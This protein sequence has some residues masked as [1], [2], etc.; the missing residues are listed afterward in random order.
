MKLRILQIIFL[1]AIICVS[2]KD[3]SKSLG[4]YPILKASL[5]EKQVSIHDIFKEAVIIPLETTQESPFRYPE[6]ICVYNDTVYVFDSSLNSLYIFGIDGKYINKIHRVGQGPEEYIL[7]YDFLVNQYDN[8]IELLNPMGTIHKYRMDGTFVRRDDLPKPPMNYRYF[9]LLD[10]EYYAVWSMVQN[11]ENSLNIL[12]SENYQN[13]GGYFPHSGM[14]GAFGR[15][16]FYL[17]NDSLYYYECM[18]NKVYHLTQDG[19]QTVYEWDFGMGIIDPK[20]LSAPLEKVNEA[21]QELGED[22]KEGK[23]PFCFAQQFQTDK[24]YYASLRFG[25]YT[26]KSLFYDKSTGESL[27][28]E[29][30]KEGIK[31]IPGIMTNEYMIGLLSYEDKETLRSVVSPA[32]AKLLDKMKEEDNMWLVK[33]TFK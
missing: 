29:K 5:V 26:Q 6:K 24:Y 18:A 8:T 22:F 17:Y 20:R 25:F 19:Y 27:F 23:I 31:L 7:V 10:K 12:T 16:V 11:D 9:E 15:A 30:T 13:F 4:E 3:S 33:F 21:L 32:D 2:C 28:F 1:T 14:W